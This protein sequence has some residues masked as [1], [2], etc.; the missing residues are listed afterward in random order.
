M[1]E[2]LQQYIVSK[3]AEMFRMELEKEI[4]NLRTIRDVAQHNAK[5]NLLLDYY[6]QGYSLLPRYYQE[7]YLKSL[8]ASRI[9]ST[10]NVKAFSFSTQS[11]MK[12]AQRIEV[13]EEKKET[14]EL[15]INWTICN[16][17][18][19]K[20]VYESNGRS[21]RINELENCEI[22]ISD[23]VPSLSLNSLK[24]CVFVA[25]N[26]SGSAR[27]TNCHH[28]KF[29][30]SLKQLRIHDTTETDFYISVVGNPIIEGCTK[31]RFAP[32]K[33]NE[34]GPWNDVK[35]FDRATQEEPSPNW[36][37]IPEEQ[38]KIPEPNCSA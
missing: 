23:D 28:C 16:K 5:V 18:N 13:K 34:S 19:E 37:I 14:E 7:K 30:L 9:K 1:G 24:N 35:D 11:K 31:L 17:K 29:V 3:N 27:I 20:I 38:Q 33:G 22:K 12:P 25:N 15:D 2:K 10:G 6:H 36:C 26:I 21:V 4:A 32:L 8:E